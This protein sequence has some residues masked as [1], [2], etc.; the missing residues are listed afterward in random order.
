MPD[1]E[2]PS[3][4]NL[5]QPSRGRNMFWENVRVKVEGACIGAV[6]TARVSVRPHTAVPC[7]V[8]WWGQASAGV[9]LLWAESALCVLDFLVSICLLSCAASGRLCIANLPEAAPT[10][11][12]PLQSR[13]HSLHTSRLLSAWLITLLV[14][15]T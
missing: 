8:T 7:I 13:S 11:A 15:R 9:M 2:Q 6:V 14:L 12:A 1:L 4:D 5:A 10:E 3:Q